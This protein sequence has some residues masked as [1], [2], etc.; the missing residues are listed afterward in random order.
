MA[1]KRSSARTPPRQPRQ[2]ARPGTGNASSSSGAQP[3]SGTYSMNR[4]ER[5]SLHPPPPRNNNTGGG[6]G[7]GAGGAAGY[8]G[9]VAASG[10]M[11]YAH[12]AAAVAG[13]A[14]MGAGTANFGMPPMSPEEADAARRHLQSISEALAAQLAHAGL[15]GGAVPPNA[16]G[17]GGGGNPSFDNLG[18]GGLEGIAA[19]IDRA[20]STG[21]SYGASTAE[22]LLPPGAG[23]GG[24]GTRPVQYGPVPPPPIPTSR[25]GST[26][27]V[28]ISSR[29]GGTTTFDLDADGMTSL[30]LN[31]DAIGQMIGL[32]V[33]QGQGGT[34]GAG[35][36][37]AQGNFNVSSARS[38]NNRT[39]SNR[40]NNNS[41]NRSPNR[42]GNKRKATGGGH[43]AAT[44]MTPD[45]VASFGQMMAALT[46]PG[47]GTGMGGGAVDMT[48]TFNGPG[49]GNNN[50]GGGGGNANLNSGTSRNASAAD[51]ALSA[52]MSAAGDELM[53][54]VPP[55]VLN[56]LL[57]LTNA[58][59]GSAS[60]SE[61]IPQAVEM[62]TAAL[63]GSSFA[64]L[65][66]R[67]EADAATLRSVSRA[68]FEAGM[69]A[70]RDGAPVPSGSQLFSMMFGHLGAVGSG[71]IGE[72][73]RAA[74]QAPPPPPQRRSA[75][76]RPRQSAAAQDAPRRP[77]PPS[78]QSTAGTAV[79]NDVDCSS[80]KINSNDNNNNNSDDGDDHPPLADEPSPADEEA[81]A[82]RLKK[83]A[84]KRDKKAR[85]KEAKRKEAEAK[86][87]AAEK[88]KREKAIT[89]WRSRVIAACK[90]GDRRGMERLVGE[91][92]YRNCPGDLA[93]IIAN[94]NATLTA[95]ATAAANPNAD[96]GDNADGNNAV[97]EEEYLRDQLEWLVNSCV[98]KYPP[99]GLPDRNTSTLNDDDS[100]RLTLVSY[101]LSACPSVLTEGKDGGRSGLHSAALGNDPALLGWVAD[102]FDDVARRADAGGW[103]DH[104]L[105]GTC[106]DAGWTP[107]HY[108]VAGG[109]AGAVEELLGRGADAGARTDPELTRFRR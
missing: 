2:P 62:L 103:A 101:I 32:S 14:G 72:A 87:A 102:H 37:Y 84:K 59:V 70:A 74:Q 8:Y 15:P 55:P 44:N 10:T 86:A 81:E 90:G 46:G 17:G 80:G 19:A 71:G 51:Q 100:A 4:G 25:T 47:G 83:A 9:N 28:S 57:S 48:M 66:V 13:G 26:A 78:R 5:M 38:A 27:S 92:P 104:P 91:S 39:N 73:A 109:A 79:G 68:A 53:A 24:G 29:D 63:D 96:D 16:G 67:T 42:S 30:G 88:K 18:M 61:S 82:A 40:S 69:S 22:S 108:A 1:K 85:Q 89:S 6:A 52:S 99:S 31:L 35:G 93:N 33:A 56:E 98:Q 41:T 76:A 12:H 34:G 64:G 23:G 54:G 7:V 45:Q 107:L 21:V 20:I 50:A 95:N 75:A 77:D 94:A 65:G 105:D 43:M 36:N 58:I 49:G 97:A 106:G 11:N 60:S 3:V